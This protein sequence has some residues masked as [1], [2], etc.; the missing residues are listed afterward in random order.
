MSRRLPR[1]ALLAVL[2]AAH[3]GCL[4]ASVNPFYDDHAL[5]FDERLLGAWQS[6][7][8]GLTVT[9]ERSEWRSYRLTYHVPIEDGVLTGYLFT[10]DDA[11][12][13]DLTPVRGRDLGSFVLPLHRVARVRVED[14]A[15]VVRPL[16][17][18][19]LSK[20]VADGRLPAALLATTV[21]HD[22]VVFGAA[23]EALVR[24]LASLGAD[25]PAFAPE[26]RL[27]RPGGG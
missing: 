13:I 24:W 5:T 18:D 4:V 22:R 19:A 9:V 6:E 27:T 15:L 8:D 1:A 26:V 17:F 3:G 16:S 14:G 11:I 21:E 2:A 25:D 10:V 23:S 20:A 12:W 7:D